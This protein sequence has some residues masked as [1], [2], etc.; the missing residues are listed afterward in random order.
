MDGKINMSHDEMARRVDAMTDEEQQHFKQIIM[1]VVLCF[2]DDAMQGL[3][4]TSKPESATLGLFTIN[5]GEMEAATMLLGA[6][7]YVGFL[8]MQDAPAKEKFN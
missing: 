8:N 3:F 7:D 6:N 5:C 2:G 1:R 4:I